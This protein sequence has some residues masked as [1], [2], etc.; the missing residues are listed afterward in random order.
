MSHKSFAKKYALTTYG[1][2]GDTEDYFLARL[3]FKNMNGKRVLD[4]GCGPVAKITS[5][6]YPQAEEVVCV[7]FLKENLDFVR[8]GSKTT[9]KQIDRALVYKHRYLSKKD[10]NPKI[11]LIK[12]DVSKRLKLGKFDSVMQLG[13]FGCLNSNKDFEAAVSHAYHYLKKGGTLV[14]VNWLDEKHKADKRYGFNP[15][16]HASS[17]KMYKP[18]M[19]KAG[20]KIKEFHVTSNMSPFSKKL[21]FTRMIWAIAKK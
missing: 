4:L 3:I 16:G 17:L 11:K 21:G 20:F 9:Q 7:D 12:G 2:D 19:K 8:T 14:M 18:S 1:F 15:G 13:C 5:I 6:F 10:A